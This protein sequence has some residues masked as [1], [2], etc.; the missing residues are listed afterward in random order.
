MC[1]P[2]N[3]VSSGSASGVSSSTH[4]SGSSMEGSLVS[5]LAPSGSKCN[6]DGDV[7]RLDSTSTGGDGSF[8]GLSG[9]D[10][11]LKGAGSLCLHGSVVLDGFGV[12]HDH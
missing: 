1:G 9:S 11:S 8:V 7:V 2:L 4:G 6:S 5:S 3:V 12:E 10:P